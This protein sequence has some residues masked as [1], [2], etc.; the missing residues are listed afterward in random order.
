[1]AL[2]NL[3]E[4]KTGWPGS[5]LA[6]GLAVTLRTMTRKTK[7]AQYPDALPELPPRSRG[8]IGLFEENCT[9]CMLCARECPDWC[10]YIDS[11]KETV[12]PATPGGR[13]RS[14]NVLDRFAIDFALCMYCGICIEVCPF[15]AL[16]WSPE[17]EY[18]ETDI[19]ELTHERDK[20][21]EWMW[22]VPAPPALDPAAEEPKEIAT[23]RKTA[24]KR[25]A[26]HAAE[27]A[28]AT[29]ATPAAPAT[30]PA[31]ESGESAAPGESSAPGTSG[32]SGASGEGAPS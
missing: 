7:T 12:P 4:K 9:V 17:F 5:G 11:H 15:D 22:T 2:D 16:F 20:L 1:M 6:K 18:A 32:T 19:R 14:Q 24:D 28:A 8:V 30:P 3:P 10:I 27:A 26:A 23:A 29:E 25:A 31:G 21:R 13:E